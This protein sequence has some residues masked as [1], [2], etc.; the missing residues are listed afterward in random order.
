MELLT[1]ITKEEM[2]EAFKD[3]EL[4]YYL[5]IKASDASS[6][7]NAVNVLARW[8]YLLFNGLTIGNPE[9]GHLYQWMRKAGEVGLD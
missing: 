5:L 8:D 2:R 9:D 3:Q 1:P 6:M 4:D 7:Q